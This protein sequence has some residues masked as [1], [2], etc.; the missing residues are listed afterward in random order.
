M[1]IRPNF[2]Y[3]ILL[4]L[5]PMSLPSHFWYS[6]WILCVLKC[7]W[8]NSSILT[9]KL[10]SMNSTMMIHHTRHHSEDFL[11]YGTLIW[12]IWTTTVSL[13]VIFNCSCRKKSTASIV[14]GYKIVNLLLCPL[15]SLTWST[16]P[17]FNMGNRI[18]LGWKSSDS[19]K[20]TC[21]KK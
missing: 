5:L 6:F 21:L 7:N 14:R 20:W 17:G 15:A 19:T 18:T 3:K 10:S 16:C 9:T 13:S 1:F 2:L 12:I 8:G 11:A 4:K